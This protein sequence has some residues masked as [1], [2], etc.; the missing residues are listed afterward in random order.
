MKRR[1]FIALTAGATAAWSIGAR[2]QTTRMPRV[3]ILAITETAEPYATLF[4]QGLREVGYVEGKSVQVDLRVAQKSNLLPQLAA[5][6]IHL[7]ADVIASIQTQATHAARNA[8]KD[9]PI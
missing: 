6:L 1:H 8:T 7:G 5:E 4:R 2:A 3:G 9:V